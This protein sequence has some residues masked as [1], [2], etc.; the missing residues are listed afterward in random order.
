MKG[1]ATDLVLASNTV[2]N[3]AGRFAVKIGCEVRG[4]WIIQ[5]DNFETQRANPRK[6]GG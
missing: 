3:Q 5:T 1:A 4:F 6:I 2:P